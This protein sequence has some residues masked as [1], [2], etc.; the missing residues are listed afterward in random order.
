[1]III[2]VFSLIVVI[3]IAPTIVAI[4]CHHYHFRQEFYSAMPW[5]QFPSF[6]L[7]CNFIKTI[8]WVSEFAKTLQKETGTASEV[9]SLVSD[10]FHHFL[11]T[12]Q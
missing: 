2:T 10:V 7:F 11:E 4:N 3:L 12:R 5:R 1:M 8:V 9:N 6:L